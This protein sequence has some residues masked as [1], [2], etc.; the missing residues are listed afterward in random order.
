MTIVKT[1]FVNNFTGS[2]E[3]LNSPEGQRNIAAIVQSVGDAGPQV[4][5]PADKKAT[6]GG[7]LKQVMEP[8]LQA[9]FSQFMTEHTWPEIGMEGRSG[10]TPTVTARGAEAYSFNPDTL[11]VR[12]TAP[13]QLMSPKAA[14]LNKLVKDTL[15]SYEA[16]G[17]DV[18]PLKDNIRNTF[19]IN[20]GEDNGS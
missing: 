16:L 14:S 10:V 18:K 2:P 13:D 4:N 11:E 12:P 6:L 1:W 17:I 20:T 7:L 8:K 9:T 15:N 3:K 19:G 5:I